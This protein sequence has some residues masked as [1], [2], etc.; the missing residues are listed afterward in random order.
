MVAVRVSV[1]FN[2]RFRQ[3]YIEAQRLCVC[4]YMCVCLGGRGDGGRA[5]GSAREEKANEKK[6]K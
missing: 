6:S 5:G 4:M 2:L 1:L 3:H